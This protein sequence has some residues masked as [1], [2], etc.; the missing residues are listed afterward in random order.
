MKNTL[1]KYH[2]VLG[3]KGNYKEV[4]DRQ[5]NQRI[6]LL[7]GCCSTFLSESNLAL[8]CK[9]IESQTMHSRRFATPANCD[10]QYLRAEVQKQY[11][12]LNI[13]NLTD[14]KLEHSVTLDTAF[15]N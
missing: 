1:M 15:I 6:V 14:V 3:K 9:L 5:E 2:T 12:F 8:D 7:G 11:D 10:L 13:I 4:R